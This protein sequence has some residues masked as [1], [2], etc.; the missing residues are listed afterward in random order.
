MN[1]SFWLGFYA[2]LDTEQLDYMAEK[3]EEFLG[4]NF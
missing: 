2:A 1:D 4:L 3:M